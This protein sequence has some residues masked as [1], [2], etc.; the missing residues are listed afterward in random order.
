M[1]NTN[2]LIYLAIGIS[3]ITLI[4]TAGAIASRKLNFKYTYLA[5]ISLVIYITIGYF[6]SK[7][8]GLKV[9]LVVNGLLGLFDGTAGLKLSILLKANTGIS[10]EE[11]LKKADTKTAILMSLLAILFGLIGFGITKLHP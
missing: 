7:E 6:I 2:V 11:S 4:S 3:L 10:T 5:I 8:H 1:N 9:C